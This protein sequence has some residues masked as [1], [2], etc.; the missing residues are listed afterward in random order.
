MNANRRDPQSDGG[1]DPRWIA[2]HPRT[3]LRDDFLE[4]HPLLA[5]NIPAGGMAEK[6]SREEMDLMLWLR[7]PRLY[8]EALARFAQA[9]PCPPEE[10][11]H[12]FLER[13][14][15]KELV[16]I[17]SD[18]H[19]FGRPAP[20][21]HLCIAPPTECVS[22][23]MRTP[24]HIYLEATQACNLNCIHCFS[25]E[26]GRLAQLPLET[27]EDLL[28]QMDELGVTA[29]TLSGGEPTL[30]PDLPLILEKAS[31]SRMGITL[32][33]N[34]TLLEERDLLDRIIH[35]AKAVNRSLT[36]GTSFDAVTE[37]LHDRIRGAAGSLRRTK[38][39]LEYLTRH[40]FRN[41]S[42]QFMLCRHN[43]H[44]VEEVMSWAVNH[45]I[46][47]VILFDLL[48]LGRGRSCDAFHP[49]PA[50]EEWMTARSFDLLARY[51][52]RLE[53]RLSHRVRHL[54][55]LLTSTANSYRERPTCLAGMGEFAIR[56]DGSVHPCSYVWTEDFLL[57][58]VRQSPLL[59]LWR[60]EKLDFFRGGYAVSELHIC[61]RCQFKTRCHLKE[62]RALPI[63]AGDRYGA[64]QDICMLPLQETGRARFQSD[65]A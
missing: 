38:G 46:K 13:F 41:I 25:T 56:A 4:G 1:P 47:R 18:S 3:L 22:Q 16:A 28:H 9:A 57:G 43:I 49:D 21:D 10:A 55:D 24:N 58:N 54:R 8:R 36:L 19:C 42:L 64:Y 11:E 31:A 65:L 30:H 37:E 34:A 52:N 59:S 27:L 5:L 12:T 45:G 2:L 17:R 29:L 63:M 7:E 60:S 53:I 23:P 33:T 20:Q 39:A 50:Q 44:E 61:S 51:G 14:G 62:C 48:H 15:G 32:L 35:L 40:G 26:G 6:L